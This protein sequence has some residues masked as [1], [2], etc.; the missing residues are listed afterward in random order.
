MTPN[1]TLDKFRLREIE[2]KLVA[3]LHATREQTRLAA[4]EEEKRNA[5]ETYLLAL[6]RFSEF[7]AKGIVP[8]EFLQQSGGPH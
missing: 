5:L 6:Q 8:D 4:T 1:S 3:D 2:R 7:A